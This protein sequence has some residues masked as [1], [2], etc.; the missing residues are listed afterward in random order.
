VARNPSDTRAVEPP[1]IVPYNPKWPSRFEAEA[2]S[3]REALGDVA[4]RIEHVGST[5]VPGL[6]AK[7]T[8]DIQVSV[9]TMDRSLYEAPL[10]RLGYTSVWDKATHEHHFFGR[11]YT[12]GPRLFNVHVCPVGSEWERRHI[13]FRDYLRANPSAAERYASFKTEI[14]PNFSDTLEYAYAKEEFIR[15]MEREAGII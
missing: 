15:E 10:E 13:A 4:V 5:A 12:T 3:I 9:A 14:A 6:A 2:S 7:D 8:I 11:P 1:I